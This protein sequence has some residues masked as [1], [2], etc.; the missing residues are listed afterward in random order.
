MREE[1]DVMLR[2]MRFLDCKSKPFEYISFNHSLTRESPC[3]QR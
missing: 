2:C 1:F 3:A